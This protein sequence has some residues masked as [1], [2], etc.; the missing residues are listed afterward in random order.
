MAAKPALSHCSNRNSSVNVSVAGNVAFFGI[1]VTLRRHLVSNILAVFEKHRADV[2]A[3]NV[4][5]SDQR[6]LTLS[7]TAVVG[8]N[9]DGD[10]VEKIKRDILVI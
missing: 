9:R 6:R 2:L 5:V 7:V 8:G 4:S 1:Q 3:A 10:V